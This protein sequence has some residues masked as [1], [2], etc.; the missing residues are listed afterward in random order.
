M[1]FLFIHLFTLYTA[2]AAQEKVVCT[3]DQSTC[4][5]TTEFGVCS[6]KLKS[7]QLVLYKKNMMIWENKSA[8]GNSKVTLNLKNDGNL[9]MRKQNNILWTSNSGNSQKIGKYSLILTE[10]CT[11]KIVNVKNNQVW[12]SK[13]YACTGECPSELIDPYT[14]SRFVV[15]Q[16]GN[17]V[18]YDRNRNVMWTSGSYGKGEKPYKLFMQDDGNLVLYGNNKLVWASNT[19]GQGIKPCLLLL[20]FPFQPAGFGLF[21]GTNRLSMQ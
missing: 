12:M 16:G 5:D 4:P 3:S 10:D 1:L 2:N 14:Q 19:N 18:M 15:Q 13:P 6:L 20:G 17:I 11:L 9:V 7:E 8:G 21:C